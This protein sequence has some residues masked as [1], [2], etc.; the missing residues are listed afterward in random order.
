MNTTE[1]DKWL[2]ITVILF[3]AGSALLMLY[4]LV[5]D[6]LGVYPFP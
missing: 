1:K 2:K 3:F 4:L 5:V 6:F